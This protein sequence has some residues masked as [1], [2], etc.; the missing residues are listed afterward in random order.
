MAD[1]DAALDTVAALAA[2]RQFVLSLGGFA[3][4]VAGGVLVTH[5]RVPAPRF[6]FVEVE[7]VSPERQ[8]AFFERALDHY[9]QR[10]IRPVFRLRDRPPNHL[11][12]ALR[13]FGF[14]ARPEPL[15][16]LLHDG[17]TNG[18]VA[19]GVE[20]RAARPDE[21]DRV[22]EVWTTPRDRPELRA[23]LETV[24][25][26]PNP[27]ERLAPLLA[28][29]DGEVA[30]AAVVYRHGSTSGVHL[31]ATAP[32]A[33]GRGAASAL[34]AY[35]A[36]RHPAGPSNRTFLLADSTLALSPLGE[37]GFRPVERFRVYDLPPS[38]E[39]SL[40]PPGP[41]APPRWRPPRGDRP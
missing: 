33:R 30:S 20:V 8:T 21:L 18:E 14:V 13:K 28:S 25:S 11:D 27:S 24:W 35:A 32:P 29:V 22:A 17:R 5:E 23:A 4:E 9:F 41:P 38:A 34:V 1:G 31:A 26:H 10:A 37:V 2:E 39:L 19:P 36:G 3:L 7:E 16:L 12:A 6:N 40:P 15:S